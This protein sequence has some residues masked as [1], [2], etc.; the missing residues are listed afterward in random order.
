MLGR[1]CLAKWTGMDLL[2]RKSK[3]CNAARRTRLSASFLRRFVSTI[4]YDL[5]AELMLNQ[6]MF[7]LIYLNQLLLVFLKQQSQLLR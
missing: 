6:P 1:T 4:F 3:V 7:L 2:W 5:V